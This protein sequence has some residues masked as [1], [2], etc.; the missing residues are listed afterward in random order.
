MKLAAHRHTNRRFKVISV[1]LLK[2]HRGE[3]LGR[4]ETSAFASLPESLSADPERLSY[5]S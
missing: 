5:R 3:A 4:E 1:T 2:V